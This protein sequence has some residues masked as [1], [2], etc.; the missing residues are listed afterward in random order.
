MNGTPWFPWENQGIPS[1]SIKWTLLKT[2]GH[3]HSCERRAM[4]QTCAM[5]YGLVQGMCDLLY[6]SLPSPPFFDFF[7]SMVQKGVGGHVFLL[8]F[9]HLGEFSNTLEQRSEL[10]LLFEPLSTTSRHH[11]HWRRCLQRCPQLPLRLC[12]VCWP[13]ANFFFY[14]I[15]VS[16]L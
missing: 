12:K 15:I 4:A 6:E 1:S 9:W 14:K 3:N 8:Q 11:W 7:L 13:L 16:C 10:L 2:I 5:F